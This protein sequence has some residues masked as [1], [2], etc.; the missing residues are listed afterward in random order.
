ML[1]V[2]QSWNRA[3]P[4]GIYEIRRNHRESLLNPCPRR[5]FADFGQNPMNRAR[6]GEKSLINSLGQGIFFGLCPSHIHCGLA[7]GGISITSQ[8]RFHSFQN[9]IWR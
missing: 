4:R 7:V 6:N 8:K 3:K 9:Y 5:T 2:Y 1:F